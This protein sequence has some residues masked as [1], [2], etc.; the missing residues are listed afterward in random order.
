MFC[1]ARTVYNNSNDFTSLHVSMCACFRTES[2]LSLT[3]TSLTCKVHRQIKP[4]QLNDLR[5][6]DQPV[7]R[8][9]QAQSGML[10]AHLGKHCLTSKGNN[11]FRR[12]AGRTK[13]RRKR[14]RTA[15]CGQQIRYPTLWQ[16]P[17]APC[18][19]VRPVFDFTYQYPQ[20]ECLIVH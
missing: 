20:A 19:Q 6:A 9:G 11:W 14:L 18:L 1:I 16:L 3:R 17:M 8:S 15:Y 5:L 12:T 4:V 13:R 10:A 2:K 7:P